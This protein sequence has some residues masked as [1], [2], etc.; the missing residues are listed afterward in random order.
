VSEG[1]LAAADSPPLVC[2]S[3]EV[4]VSSVQLLSLSVGEG[5][6]VTLVVDVSLGDGTVT[7]ATTVASGDDIS[8]PLTGTATTVSN[9]LE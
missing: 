7:A 9:S 4:N 3:I 6:G 5:I 2:C 1:L 8:A